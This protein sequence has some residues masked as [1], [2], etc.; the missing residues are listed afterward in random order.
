MGKY[1]HSTLAVETRKE[2]SE[3]ENRWTKEKKA[4]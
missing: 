4:V 3:R 2:N 1:V